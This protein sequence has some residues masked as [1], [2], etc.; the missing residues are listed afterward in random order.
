MLILQDDTI[1][2]ICSHAQ[3]EYPKECCGIMLGKRLGEQRIVYSIIQT[4][5]MIEENQNKTHFLMNPIEIV[6]AELSAER[7]KLEI[8][9]FYHSHPD[10][11]AVASNEDVLHMITGYSYLIISAKNGICVKVNSFEKIMQTDT[12]AKE[13]EILV[14]EK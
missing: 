2:M 12:D 14:K 5:N 6:K 9:G 3:N 4:R 11:E 10:Y 1:E 8:V 7:E 13:E